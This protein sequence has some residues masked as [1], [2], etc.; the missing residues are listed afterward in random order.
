MKLESFGISNFK[1]FGTGVQQIPLKPITLIFGPNSAGKSSALHSLLW[2]HHAVHQGQID[3]RFPEAGGGRV[4]L[5][6]F[7][8]L[9]HR[10]D[11]KGKCIEVELVIGKNNLPQE[12]L[13]RLVI[14][15]KVTVKL[16]FGVSARGNQGRP[17]LIGYGIRIDD[18]EF[19]G[20]F[21]NGDNRLKIEYLDSNMLR[22]KPNDGDQV[23]LTAEDLK[24][25]IREM[26]LK[27]LEIGGSELGL[28][29]ERFQK[30]D[31]GG[32][33]GELHG[34]SWLPT[35]M[36]SGF[37]RSDEVGSL[38]SAVEVVVRGCFE[39]LRYVPPL[40]D[41]PGRYFDLSGADA[42]WQRLFDQPKLLR[43]I[44]QW[45]DSDQF[46]TKYELVV[47][48]YLSR[49]ALEKKLPALLRRIYAGRAL[50]LHV[51]AAYRYDDVASF[52]AELTPVLGALELKFK[53]VDPIGLIQS[54]YNLRELA[55]QI[56]FEM[57]WGDGDKDNF[58][59]YYGD[60]TSRS[61]EEMGKE[62]G[63][64]FFREHWD[65]VDFEDMFGP[66]G[67]KES[68]NVTDSGVVAFRAWAVR[69]PELRSLI[70]CY[71][72]SV[73]PAELFISHEINSGGN[74][75]REIVLRD[76]KHQAEVS[77]QDVGVGI[78]QVLP[79]VLH[80]FGEKG[81]IIAIEQPEIHIH[82]AL[83]SELGD[84][85][86]ESALGENKNTLLLETHSE[87]LILRLLRRIRETT[88][89]DFSSWSESLK[90]ACPDGIKPEDIAVLY[91]QPGEE[92]SEIIELPVTEDGD[93]SR[94]WPG[95]FFAERSKELF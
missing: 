90:R 83:Q 27:N 63:M 52:V 45:L 25:M 14:E 48:E 15:E 50:D 77:L 92:G 88:E 30:F 19:L 51:E 80:A 41:L 22:T 5:G 67:Y 39:G 85:F 31:D 24:T 47:S 79:V 94:P 82:P 95:G 54:D 68:G 12:V 89:G 7:S 74:V 87:H 59:S 18:R 10:S 6:S 60:F 78:S 56:A 49:T 32:G 66:K 61:L 40:R 86:I 36:S 4:D 93:F 44:N 76:K 65:V 53:G 35:G 28:L 9:L 33:K 72:D 81:K 42:S 37:P 3:F 2:M 34:D 73:E 75:R 43:K 11:D 62:E 20:A 1:A 38:M 58:L 70:D 29:L 21:L 23:R 26:G 57:N 46:R 64:N 69:Q 91:I 71:F 84:V 13:A 16:T 17:S 55:A 8:R